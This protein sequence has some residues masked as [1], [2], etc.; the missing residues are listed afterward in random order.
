VSQSADVH[1]KN[2]EKE[3]NEAN[4]TQ[5]YYSQHRNVMIFGSLLIFVEAAGAK[6]TEKI[7]S[8]FGGG[9]SFDGSI[10]VSI[11]FL[12]L[13]LYSYTHFFGGVVLAG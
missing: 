11:I 3:N 10:N 9:L 4:L 6:L 8:Q 2:D 13:L 12:L 7:D 1:S 5:N